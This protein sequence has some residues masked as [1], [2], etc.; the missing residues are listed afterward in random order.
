M[1]KPVCYIPK[2]GSAVLGECGFALQ[3][4]F[5]IYDGRIRRHF[6]YDQFFGSRSGL[7]P[8]IIGSVGPGPHPG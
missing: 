3:L 5:K 2:E 4:C 8:G 1:I 6:S 7:D